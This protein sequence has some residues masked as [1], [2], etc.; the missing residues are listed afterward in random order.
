MA[1]R[2]IGK[3]LKPE[4]LESLPKCALRHHGNETDCQG[5]HASHAAGSWPSDSALAHAV[6]R[7]AHPTAHACYAGGSQNRAPW[8]TRH[9]PCA[10]GSTAAGTAA[11]NCCPR[12]HCPGAGPTSACWAPALWCLARSA[13]CLPMTTRITRRCW[14]SRSERSCIAL[15]TKP[16]KWGS[17]NTS[18]G[19]GGGGQAAQSSLESVL[20]GGL[21]LCYP[22][23]WMACVMSVEQPQQ[24]SV[25]PSG[26]IPTDPPSFT[27]CCLADAHAACCRCLCQTQLDAAEL[28]VPRGEAHTALQHSTA[29][30][31]LKAS[32]Y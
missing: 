31:S 30:P 21:R 5:G 12:P 19:G 2:E 9:W 24:H 20:A 10:C 6:A 17:V 23:T 22:G 28:G 16:L 3:F 14:R 27:A 32:G 7:G 18:R 1:L 4:K 15:A 26:R 29:R 13:W 8:R 25:D 11:D